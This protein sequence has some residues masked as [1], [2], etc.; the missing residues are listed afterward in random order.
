MRRRT[1]AACHVQFRFRFN[2][3]ASFS[4]SSKTECTHHSCP[5]FLIGIAVKRG[6]H[7]AY[8]E[9]IIAVGNLDYGITA[10][11][12]IF[13]LYHNSNFLPQK[14]ARNKPNVCR[15]LGRKKCYFK[16]VLRIFLKITQGYDQNNLRNW[17]KK[18]QRFAGKSLNL[19][20]IKSPEKA[21]IGS[22]P[23]LDF[24]NICNLY[25]PFPAISHPTISL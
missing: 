23:S 24:T 3:I 9:H 19:A 22:N 10:I 5:G 7:L 6:T 2:C 15:A 25:P 16:E 18:A 1:A 21:W 11:C 20:P 13:K 8:F 4:L 14:Y 12:C 17:Q